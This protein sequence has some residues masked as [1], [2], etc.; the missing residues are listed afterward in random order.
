MP[1]GRETFRDFEQLA[2]GVLRKCHELEKDKLRYMLVTNLNNCD[3]HSVMGLALL[4]EDEQFLAEYA[5]KE[6]VEEIWS[7]GL[8]HS[9][10]LTCKALLALLLPVFGPLF[11]NYD[12]APQNSCLN[13]FNLI[14]K[15]VYFCNAPV[16]S[17]WSNIVS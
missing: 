16:V 8:K 2:A 11:L 7:G 10:N 3:S 5:C 4:A 1:L 12:E 17:F 14:G 6:A 9:K 15:Y 13:K